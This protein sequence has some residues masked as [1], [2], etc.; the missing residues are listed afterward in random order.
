MTDQPANL[1]DSS[2]VWSRFAALPEVAQTPL[3]TCLQGRIP[4]AYFGAK[5]EL[6]DQAYKEV[7]T[8][9]IDQ[10]LAGNTVGLC[11]AGNIGVGKSSAMYLIMK[12]VLTAQYV[13]FLEGM[14]GEIEHRNYWDG[15][16]AVIATKGNLIIL[17]H[18]ELTRALRQAYDGNERFPERPYFL[19]ASYLF[20]DD[21][22]R[23]Y[24]DR[25][26]WNVALLEEYIDDRWRNKRP[27]F[28]TTNKRPEELRAWDGYARII[29][30]LL[31]PAWMRK[32][33]IGGKSKRSTEFHNRSQTVEGVSNE[34]R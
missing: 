22:G 5:L 32:V 28:I 12:Y 21:F 20:V 31:D 2:T 26:G 9:T 24:D 6:V 15:E 30:R 18:F 11:L 17:T 3:L 7:I 1:I 10:I 33:W 14:E 25:S 29:D 23:G 13:T 19:D 34:E 4:L 27:M 8:Q 16:R